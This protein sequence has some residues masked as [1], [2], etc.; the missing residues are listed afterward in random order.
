MIFPL[1][2]GIGVLIGISRVALGVHTWYDIGG[3]I[4]IAGLSYNIAN[5]ILRRKRTIIY[6]AHEGGRQTIQATFGLIFSVSIMALGIREVFS[7]LLVGTCLG[8]FIVH[9]KIIELNIPFIDMMLNKFERGGVVPGEGSLYYALGMLFVLGLLRDHT[10]A[11]VCVVI[12]VSVS[13][14]LSTYIGKSFGRYVL[15]W[16]STKTIEGSLSFLGSALCTLFI[17]PLPVT[18]VVVIVGTLVESLPI[19]LNDNIT[20]PVILSMLFYF[21]LK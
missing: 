6:K 10:L 1:A 13:D 9:L 12:I 15:P 21:P 8:I 16:N 20:L 7:L 18:I 4:A 3:G 2:F 11:A 14:A 17:L 19:E 5:T